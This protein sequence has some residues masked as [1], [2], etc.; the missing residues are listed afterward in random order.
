MSLR[1]GFDLRD[2]YSAMDV[3]AYEGQGY[4]ATRDN[5]DL[6]G[7]DDG[8]LLIAA[9]GV[10]ASGANSSRPECAGIKATGVRPGRKLMSGGSPA[11]IS[12]LS[13]FFPT[14]RR[15]RN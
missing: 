11:N 8:R 1:G 7:V 10:K 4:I 12:A 2:C 5:P 9:R 6:P 15:G 3:V 14:G 13:H